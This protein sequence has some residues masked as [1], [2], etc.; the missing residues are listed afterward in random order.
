MKIA[1]CGALRGVN[2]S[3][4]IP[5]TFKEKNLKKSQQVHKNPK[6]STKIPKNPQKST[7]NPLKSQIP[8]ALRRSYLPGALEANEGGAR[9]QQVTQQTKN[10]S[11]ILWGVRIDPSFCF[12]NV[13]WP[14]FRNLKSE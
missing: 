9:R 6:K 10:I 7:K 1:N 5:Y 8:Y 2:N 4:K 13:M 14:S 11:R 3:E 12:R